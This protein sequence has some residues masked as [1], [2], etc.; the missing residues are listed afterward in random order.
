MTYLRVVAALS[1]FLLAP[2]AQA[3]SLFKLGVEPI[4]GYERVQKLLPEPHTRQRLV[5]GARLTAGLLLFSAEAEYTRSGD[6]KEFPELGITSK[7]TDD[8]LKMGLRSSI[9]MGALLSLILRGG[10]QASRSTTED[11]AG[12]VTTKTMT[13]IQ[14]DPYL[15]LGLSASLGGK[16]VLTGNVTAIFNDFPDMAKNDYQTTLGFAIRLP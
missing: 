7:E 1:I 15:G 16:F 13:P 11:T 3:A 14:Y 10:V 12:G 6:S 8:R 9:G 2:A 5:Y 4:I